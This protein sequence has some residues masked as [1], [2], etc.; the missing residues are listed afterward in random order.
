VP[1]IV[2][3]LQDRELVVAPP[4]AEDI[5][6]PPTVG[7]KVEVVHEPTEAQVLLSLSQAPETRSSPVQVTMTQCIWYAS[8]HGKVALLAA[9]MLGLAVSS[10]QPAR[11]ATKSHGGSTSSRL[12]APGHHLPN[13]KLS[14]R[15]LDCRW[16]CSLCHL[17]SSASSLASCDPRFRVSGGLLRFA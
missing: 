9:L 16:S 10:H 15:C 2:E 12:V 8:C 11:L 5:P 7:R 14:R 13:L 3:E 4:S 1:R 17:H 6:S